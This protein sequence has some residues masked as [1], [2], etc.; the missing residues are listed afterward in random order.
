MF[1]APFDFVPDF[2]KGGGLVAAVAQDSKTGDV[3]MLAWMN[4]EAWEATLRTGE[5]HYFSRGRNR[6]W[7]KGESS[8]NVQK[9]R[10]IR[11]DCD[12][13]ALVLEIEQVGGA[14]CHEGY[15]SCFFRK[16]DEKGVSVCRSRVFDP[17]DV[18][19]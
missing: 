13:D 7:R 14:A 3:L 19:K 1:D 5:A 16:L 11:I 9:V 6:L 4:K 18:Y 15:S 10:S 12:S 8:G 2:A 17:A